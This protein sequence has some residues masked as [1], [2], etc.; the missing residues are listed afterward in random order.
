MVANMS[1]N[2]AICI[3]IDQY[4]NLQPLQYAK[5]DAEALRDFFQNEAGFDK[6]YYFAED[7]S[8]IPTDYGEPMRATPSG[9]TLR[10]FLRVRFEQKFLKPS[11]NLWFFFAGHGRRERDRDYLMPIDADPGNVQETAIPVSY[12]AERL[13]RSGAEN[14]L[15]LL[16][17]CRN[18]GAR[19]GQGVGADRQ[20]GVVTICSCSP[21]ERS[22]E[23]TEL[24]HGAFTFSLLEG[25]HLQGNSNCATIERLDQHLRFR[26]PELCQKYGKPQQTPYTHAEPIEKQH[27]VLLPRLASLSDV[28]PIK[29]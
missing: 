25:L 8:P 18:E 6:V 23:I 12:V 10:R 28:G 22:Y 16:D 13:R 14:V 5:R 17:A 26:V 1:Q 21:N 9:G 7:A 19:D 20:A 24:Q 29:L 27:L 4:D 11:D 3:G 15:L 2:W